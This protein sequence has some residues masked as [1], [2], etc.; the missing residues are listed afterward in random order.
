MQCD[1]PQ[2]GAALIMLASY[3]IPYNDNVLIYFL[4]VIDVVFHRKH[5]KSRLYYPLCIKIDR[6]P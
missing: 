6:W 4:L 2:P 1:D 3:E 5:R